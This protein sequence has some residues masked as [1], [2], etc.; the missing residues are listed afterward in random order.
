MRFFTV[1]LSLDHKVSL[2]LNTM[3]A[4]HNGYHQVEVKPAKRVREEWEEFEPNLP[5]SSLKLGFSSFS[6]VWFISFL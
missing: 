4:C 2:K 6:P 1:L 5:K 3:I